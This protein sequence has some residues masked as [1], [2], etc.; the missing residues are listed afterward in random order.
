MN[1]ARIYKLYKLGVP[2]DKETIR[3]I[4][5]LKKF[6]LN[7]R[8]YL[9]EDFRNNLFFMN[10]FGKTVIDFDLEYND[11]YIANYNHYLWRKYRKLW[12]K[13][14]LYEIIKTL[15]SEILN[16]DYVSITIDKRQITNSYQHVEK[17]YRYYRIKPKNFKN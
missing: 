3:N 11:F 7:L 15:L 9:T 14:E 6:I 5:N 17:H 12:E 10:G 4:K 2:V 8:Q 1:P 13:K 16:I